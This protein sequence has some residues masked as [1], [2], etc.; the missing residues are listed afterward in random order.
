MKARISEG[1]SPQWDLDLRYG[2][3]GEKL[4]AAFI[5]GFTNGTIEVKSDR[6]AAETGNV[7]IEAE[8]RVATGWQPSG[9]VT[10]KAEYWAIVLGEAV[11]IGVPTS[12][13]RRCYEKALQPGMEW[14]RREEKDGSHPT[15][16]VVLPLNLLLTWIRMELLRRA[17]AA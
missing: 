16:G 3:A 6:L 2:K 13:I 5:E 9:I 11:V 1:R 12:I 15:R 17:K 7:Y 14:A 4:V 8:C 10:T